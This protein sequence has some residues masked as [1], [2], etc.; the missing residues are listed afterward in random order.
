MFLEKR[1]KKLKRVDNDGSRER[2]CSGRTHASSPN[3]KV[4]RRRRTFVLVLVRSFWAPVGVFVLVLVLLLVLVRV[5]VL[6]LVL[7]LLLVLVLVL[8][9]VF[10]L[11]LVLVLALVLALVLV[12]V[13]G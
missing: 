3:S 11:V 2:I 5:L 12:L 1:K 6:V 10:V 4:C 9:L 8:V 13:F 7:V